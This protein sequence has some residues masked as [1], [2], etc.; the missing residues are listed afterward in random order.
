M[1]TLHH[2]ENKRLFFFLFFP[3]NKEPSIATSTNDF[4]VFHTEH[5]RDSYT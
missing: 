5:R 2:L 1:R 3:L 4:R